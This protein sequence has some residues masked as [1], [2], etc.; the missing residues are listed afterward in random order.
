MTAPL[1]EAV[2]L[3][4]IGQF[5][6]ITLNRGSVRVKS[7]AKALEGGS[8]GQTIRVKNEATRDVYEV[9]LTGPQEATM[10]APDAPP[11]VDGA[12]PEGL[13]ALARD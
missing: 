9:I 3:A 5:V 1:V 12:S 7:V 2:P 13:A 6:T 4:K 10:P 8:Y 11:A